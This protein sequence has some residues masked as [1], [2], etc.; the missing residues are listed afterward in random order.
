[1]WLT[2]FLFFLTVTVHCYAQ[3]WAWLLIRFIPPAY[4]SAHLYCLTPLGRCCLGSVAGRY[5]NGRP[6]SWALLQTSPTSHVK[7][8]YKASKVGKI[9]YWRAVLGFWRVVSKQCICSNANRERKVLVCCWN[10]LCLLLALCCEED[11]SKRPCVTDDVATSDLCEHTDWQIFSACS[12]FFLPSISWDLLC[13]LSFDVNFV[14]YILV[15][16]YDRICFE[17]CSEFTGLSSRAPC[18]MLLH[19]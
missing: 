7:Q 13:L 3:V 16:W 10:Y 19:G 6:C 12:V 15:L 9:W 1:M 5:I 14:V 11:H 17:F 4:R 2:F 18:L 8:G